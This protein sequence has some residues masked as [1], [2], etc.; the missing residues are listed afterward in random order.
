MWDFAGQFAAN[1]SASPAAV[2]GLNTAATLFETDRELLVSSVAV[3][4][5][6]SDNQWRCVVLGHGVS[7][8]AKKALKALR[9][10]VFSSR[11]IGSESFAVIAWKHS[12]TQ[13]FLAT[14]R[15]AS[16]AVCYS[17]DANRVSF[18]SKPELTSKLAK[19]S[20]IN[21]QA[22]FHYAFF[23]V[24]PGPE[25]VYQDVDKL[26][27]ATVLTW[28]GTCSLQ[29]Y[30]MPQFTET[31]AGK[32]EQQLLLQ[33]LE[34][35][36]AD[37]AEVNN[38]LNNPKQQHGKVAAFLS[39][40]LDSSTVVGMLSRCSN[41]QAEAFTIGFEAEGY[42][43]IPFA[44]ATAKH[45][46]VKLHEHYLTQDEVLETIPVLARSF[47]EPFGN[48]S[49]LP[50]YICAKFAADQGFTRVLAGDGGD[51]LFAGNERYAK[52]RVFKP[53][54][55]LPK[56][57]QNALLAT[58]NAIP[59]A[60]TPGILNKPRRYLEK[61]ALATP[62][63]LH[64][65]NFMA[66]HGHNSLFTADF[67][68]SINTDKP[69]QLARETFN[70]PDKASNLNRMLYSDWQFTLADNDLVKVGTSC[71]AA[72]IEVRYPMLNAEVIDLSCRIS[73]KDKLPGSKLRDFYKRSCRGFLADST[74][75]KSKKGFGLPFGVWLLEHHGLRELA[76]DSLES[77]KKR[78]IYRAEFIDDTQRLHQTGHAAYYGELVWVM[79]MLEQWFQHH[80]PN[81]QL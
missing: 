43:E 79:M 10:G 19:K 20:N 32:A 63:R 30:Y 54:E 42:D 26:P 18:S 46:G 72:E 39:G 37:C 76:G 60:A 58:V 56:P 78:G 13:A 51:E 69:L 3:A 33:S 53:F 1:G 50:S 77:L 7:G 36:T 4:D 52:Q 45:F 62:D 2:S 55:V 9:G 73:S 75:N 64:A 67:L 70:R 25:S 8:S 44:R 17:G 81:W 27:P 11:L 29:Q 24:I 16:I 59:G 65:H 74:L 38:T 23:N 68:G 47:G 61:A 22:L 5:K 21:A 40:G 28:D 14:D 80:Q 31:R 66:L 12:G 34:A 15:L 35:A 48:S 6:F 71:R 57:L 49:A 41:E